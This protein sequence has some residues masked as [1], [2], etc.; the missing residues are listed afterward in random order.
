MTDDDKLKA[1]IELPPIHILKKRCSAFNLGIIFA[2]L[3]K[4][5]E[6]NPFYHE[7]EEEKAEWWRDGFQS[8]FNERYKNSDTGMLIKDKHLYELEGIR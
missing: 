4:T 1:E 3:K 2:K 8:A 5:E 6:D 7:G